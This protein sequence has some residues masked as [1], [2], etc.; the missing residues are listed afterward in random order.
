MY[1]YSLQPIQK[2]L[3]LICVKHK[4]R[5]EAVEIYQNMQ[6]GENYEN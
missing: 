2:N 3:D 5:L 4:I 1:C 6:N